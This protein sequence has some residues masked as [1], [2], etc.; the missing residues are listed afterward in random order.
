M[1]LSACRSKGRKEE[2]AS[3]DVLDALFLVSKVVGGDDLT[4]LDDG[5]LFGA[6]L[7]VEWDVDHVAVAAEQIGGLGA[8]MEELLF[9]AILEAVETPSRLWLASLGRLVVFESH[10][11]EHV[12][13]GRKQTGRR[14]VGRIVIHVLLDFG[15]DGLRRGRSRTAC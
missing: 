14:K 2:L 13:L 10:A 15:L 8:Q 1:Q 6:R 11:V 5:V 3:G 7:V 9:L 12:G 4:E